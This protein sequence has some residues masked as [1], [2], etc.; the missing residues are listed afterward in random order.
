MLNLFFLDGMTLHTAFKFEFGDSHVPLTTQKLA[1]YRCNLQNL[2]LLIIDEISLIN[3]D[4]LYK[5][6]QHLCEIFQSDDM[7]AN[8]SVVLV[9]D[10]LQL[11][12]VQNGSRYVF[13]APKN[14]QFASYYY[15]NDLWQ[16]FEVFNLEYNHRQGD[17]NAW[18]NV[19]NQIREGDVTTE[20]EQL[21]KSRLTGLDDHN[22]LTTCHVFYRNEDV[23]AH[24]NKMLNL[25][26]G[27]PVEISAVEN[28]PG[29]YIPI[30]TSYGTIDKSGFMRI[31][32]LKLRARV[33]MISNVS[34]IDGLVNGATGNILDF[35]VN[36]KGHVDCIIVVFDSEDCGREY[37]NRYPEI[38]EKYKEDNGT[39]V[40]RRN[41][42]YQ[43]GKSKQKHGGKAK[44]LQFPLRLAWGM[45]AHKMQVKS[46]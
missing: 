33:I 35:I 36:D 2:E 14:S 32:Y 3:S 6:H 34:T 44:V 7:F 25:L 13:Q 10:L 40:F 1:E 22:E 37:R 26:P 42:E 27:H 19:L 45:T 15:A 39:P 38:S 4:F 28:V 11:P 20:T 16:Q 8:K 41:I 29:K 31:L 21:L 46:I 30:L 12:P 18:A 24:N 17:G 5:I 43:T 9:G 23:E